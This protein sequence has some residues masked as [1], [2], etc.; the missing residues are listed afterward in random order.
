MGTEE[1]LAQR[2]A[3]YLEYAAVEYDRILDACESPIERL[4]ADAL[5]DYGY[6]SGSGFVPDVVV[7]RMIWPTNGF[8]PV[9]LDGGSAH[10][11]FQ[12]EIQLESVVRVDFA[13]FDC[14]GKAA[15]A[16]EL[17]G[18]EF[19]ERT[20]EQASRDKRRDRSLVKN[21]W[22]VLRFTGSEVYENADGCLHEV[23]SAMHRLTV[24]RVQ[25]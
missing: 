16:V 15:V 23:C 22:S 25:R 8:G 7:T 5:L 20:K 13:F 10:V 21:G 2:R 18:H 24:G 6:R 12:A 1:K 9:W 11:V 19:H 4:F 3:R 14:S 17:D